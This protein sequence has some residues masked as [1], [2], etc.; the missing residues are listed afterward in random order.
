VPIGYTP[1]M[2]LVESITRDLHCLPNAKL[3]EV[4]RFI[5]ELVPQVAERQREALAESYGCMDDEQGE[6]FEQAVLKE[7]AEAEH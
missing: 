3:V 6:A 2:T 1:G 7:A 5:S 4:A